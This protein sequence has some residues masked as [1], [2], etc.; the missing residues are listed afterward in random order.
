MNE[1]LKKYCIS[2]PR[3][4]GRHTLAWRLAHLR[5]DPDAL[6]AALENLAD[7]QAAQRGRC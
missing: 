1:V 4:T 5:K 3:R 2:M 7:R 6:V